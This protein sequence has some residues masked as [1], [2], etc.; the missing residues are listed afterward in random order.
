MPAWPWI[1]RTFHFDFPVEKFPDIMERFRGTPARLEDRVRGLSRAV[2][3]WSDGGWS[4]LENIGHL[5]DLEH[6]PS[7]RLDELLAG[8]DV[9]TA[10]DMSN[11][12]TVEAAHNTRDVATLLQEFRDARLELCARFDALSPT[13]WGLTATHP[14]LRKAMRTV[15]LVYFTCEH[16]D[17][18]L[19]R[20]G[21]LVCKAPRS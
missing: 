9:L 12:Q 14:R 20:I 11:R 2:L 3:T 1:E 10:A 19:A 5:L 6:L 15:D 18:H 16:D 4:M 8:R 21:E 17:Y 7:C 13:Q